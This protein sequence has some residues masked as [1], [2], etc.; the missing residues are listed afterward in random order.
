[1]AKRRTPPPPPILPPLSPAQEQAIELLVEG[2]TTTEVA[3]ALQLSPD[4][5]QHWRDEHP[6]FQAR[7]NQAKRRRWDDAQDRLRAMIPRAIEVLEQA[8]SQG[9]VKAAVEVL[10]IVQLHGRVP[11]PSGAEDPHLVLW[12]QA[13]R[14]ATA[15]LQRDGPHD[16]RMYYDDVVHQRMTL[17]QHR[18]G[19][20]VRQ[21]TGNGSTPPHETQ[22][23]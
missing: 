21:W 15:E 9:S 17:T 22:W 14:W 16:E 5:V 3:T 1:M 2:K 19:E 6:V 11:A 4:D 10:K 23:G 18:A 8:M 20:L 12:Q 13:E 7:L